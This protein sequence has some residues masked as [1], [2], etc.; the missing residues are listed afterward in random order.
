M[1][2]RSGTFIGRNDEIR[3]Q[4]LKLP[5]GRILSYMV[6]GLGTNSETDEAIVPMN[7]PV[8][9]FFHGNIYTSFIN[10]IPPPIQ[11]GNTKMLT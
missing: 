8:V 1:C 10:F 11:N 6:D 9:I 5:D 4:K 7:K 3:G 2:S